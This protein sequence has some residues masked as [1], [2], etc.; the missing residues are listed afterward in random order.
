MQIDNGK[1]ICFLEAAGVPPQSRQLFFKEAQ[2]LLYY[3]W[4][5]ALVVLSNYYTKSVLSVP[6]GM[7]PLLP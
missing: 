6:D 5:L 3:V 7:N 4:P 1:A 2:K